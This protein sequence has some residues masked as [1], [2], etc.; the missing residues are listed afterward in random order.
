MAKLD[1]NTIIGILRG[2]IADLVFVRNADGTVH[3]RHT[4]VREAAFTP[5]ELITQSHFTQAVAYVRAVGHKPEEYAVYQTAAILRTKRACDLAH[6]D[7]R[8]PPALTDIDLSAYTGRI[9]EII[10]VQAV[11]D[12]EV[13]RVLVTITG[14]EGTLLEHGDATL[15]RQSSKW[16]YVTQVAVPPGQ[17]LA[18]HVAVSDRPG[19]TV[20][21]AVHHALVASP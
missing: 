18:V 5:G 3:T 11:D 1:P 13:L 16:E 19:N 4:P 9:G 21:K 12:F 14:L 20:L 15:D 7:F 2:K 10:R 17:T 8:C 6:A